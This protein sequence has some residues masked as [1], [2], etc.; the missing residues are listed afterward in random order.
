LVFIFEDAMVNFSHP[1]QYQSAKLAEMPQRGGKPAG[2]EHVT[3]KQ[4][5][6]SMLL[7][8]TNILAASS[9]GVEQ[10]VQR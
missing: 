2:Q 10:L 1:V 6:L 9:S 5:G 3:G 8:C 7:L 4:N